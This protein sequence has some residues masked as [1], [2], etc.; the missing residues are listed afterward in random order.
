MEQTQLTRALPEGTVLSQKYCLCKVLGV[1]G[2]GITYKGMT[3]TDDRAVAIKEFFPTDYAVREQA[4]VH[5]E[6]HILQEEKEAFD[7]ELKRFLKEAHTLREF[8]YLDGI[9]TVLD[10]FEEHGTAYIV[11]EYIESVTMKQYVRYNG[12]LHYKELV[13]LLSPVIKAMIQIHKRG[14]LHRDISP[15]NLLFGLDNQAKLIDFG[16]VYAMK[17]T[18]EHTKTVILK[19]GYAPPEQYLVKGDQGPW[20]DVYAMAATIY[21]G[22]TGRTPV[23]SVARLQGEELSS[24]CLV[25]KG[26]TEWQVHA[27]M[28]GMELKIADRYKN[29]EELLN[30]LTIPPSVEEETTQNQKELQGRQKIAA[31]K[32]ERTGGYG[33]FPVSL[34][35]SRKWLALVGSLILL[36]GISGILFALRQK[37]EKGTNIPQSSIKIGSEIKNKMTEVP[38][39]AENDRNHQIYRIPDVTELSKQDA[40]AKIRAEDETIDVQTQ[41]KYSTDIPKGYVMDQSVAGGTQYNAG[42]IQNIVLTV[43]KGA[44]KASSQP[45]DQGKN[46]SG[47]SPAAP[48]AKSTPTS[49]PET[50]TSSEDNSEQKTDTQNKNKDD[51]K[52]IEDKSDEYGE[53]TL[54]E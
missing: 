39:A 6:L 2:F 26:L 51:I 28:T 31:K 20:T 43:S 29:L 37:T 18:P 1:G 47:S 44:R 30:A 40:L 21:M 13:D 11:M 52:V 9:V 16:A 19:K 53:F 12:C 8:G 48:K 54:G 7:R 35:H 10:Y 23:D 5:P 3:L 50:S 4:A 49:K 41:E 34:S 36:L 25:D 22:L 42:A 38:A 45:S 24:D 33:I 27:V 46:G 14:I 15:D 32:A 17:D